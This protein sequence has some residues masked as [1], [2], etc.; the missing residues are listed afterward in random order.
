MTIHDAGNLSLD[1]GVEVLRSA[2]SIV[3]VLNPFDYN[4][5]MRKDRDDR[6]LFSVKCCFQNQNRW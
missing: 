3:V 5:D 6:C 1:S 2:A 4:I